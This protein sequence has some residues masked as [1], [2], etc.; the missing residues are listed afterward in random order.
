MSEYRELPL[1]ET[2]TVV[3]RTKY[4]TVNI[5]VKLF[6]RI[7]K[8]IERE[9]DF[10]TVTDYVTF[11]LREIVMAHAGDDSGNCFDSQDLVHLMK[12]LEALGAL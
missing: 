8:I 9:N 7:E 11:V 4:T 5:P 1:A 6:N 3:V 10:K 12:R 2:G